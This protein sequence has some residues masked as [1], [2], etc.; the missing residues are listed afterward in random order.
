MCSSCGVRVSCGF[1]SST[2]PLPICV[3][4]RPR[5]EAVLATAKSLSLSDTSR[6]PSAFGVPRDSACDSVAE[7]AEVTAAVQ[8]M[9]DS[10]PARVACIRQ[11]EAALVSFYKRDIDAALEVGLHARSWWWAGCVGGGVWVGVWWCVVVCVSVG[12]WVCGGMG[13]WVCGCECVGV[14]VCVRVCACACVCVCACVCGGG[15]VYWGCVV[16]SVAHCLYF[17]CSS[18]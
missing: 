7:G 16:H 17:V 13:V 9:Y 5:Y 12:L 4:F 2:P 10:I 8:A 3:P 1:T 18:H 11:L 15:G 6:C 14:W